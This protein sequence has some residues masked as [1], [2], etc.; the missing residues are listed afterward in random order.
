MVKFKVGDIY[1][2]IDPEHWITFSILKINA[3]T[4]DVNVYNRITS[5]S[6]TTSYHHNE[7]TWIYH[8]GHP[9]TQGIP[10]RW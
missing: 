8:V 7:I 6:S 9:S 10:L 4:V 3:T 2:H 5:E 1:K